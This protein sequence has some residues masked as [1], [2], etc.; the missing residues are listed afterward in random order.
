VIEF[1]TRAWFDELV[2]RAARLHA[3]LDPPLIVE[4][5]IADPTDGDIGIWHL[6]IGS[7]VEVVEGEAAAATVA[8]VCDRATAA[9]L[10]SGA[11]NAQEAISSGRLQVSGE[12][13]AVVAAAPTL[14]ALAGPDAR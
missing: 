8:L 11:L 6:R 10:A 1:A 14:V 9:L 2:A 12:I 4:Q 7:S 5:R 13:A 3:E